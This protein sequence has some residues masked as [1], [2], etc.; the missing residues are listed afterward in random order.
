DTRDTLL[1]ILATRYDASRAQNLADIRDVFQ[2][3][4]KKERKWRVQGCKASTGEGILEGL[5]WVA[6]QL[7]GE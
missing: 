6:T 7:R 5:E 3:E 2:T 4:L 1:L